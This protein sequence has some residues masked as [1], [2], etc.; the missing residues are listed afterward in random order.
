VSLAADHTQ[1]KAHAHAFF[2][3]GE[4]PIKRDLPDI[5]MLMGWA[6]WAIEVL[7]IEEEMNER[8]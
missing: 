3:G 6:D 4:L 5:F 8:E 1:A 7:L 2:H